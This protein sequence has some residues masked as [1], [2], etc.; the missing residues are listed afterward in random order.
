M[1]LSVSI[2]RTTSP[3]WPSA[4]GPSGSG[5][6]RQVPS[7]WDALAHADYDDVE[8]VWLDLSEWET[9]RERVER[10]EA[11]RQQHSADS[12]GTASP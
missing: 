11:V 4:S 7:A 9:V 5:T 12:T 8:S 1:L 2:N 3:R 10:L 6:T